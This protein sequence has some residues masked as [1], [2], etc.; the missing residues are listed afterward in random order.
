MG[1][2]NR[3]G[4]LAAALSMGVAGC[5]TF[6]DDGS[7]LTEDDRDVSVA[8]IWNEVLLEGIRNDYARPTVHARNL[9]HSSAAMYDAWAAYDDTASTW[10]LGKTQAGFRCE[11][12]PPNLPRDRQRARE[13]AISFAAYRIIRH[14]FRNSPG[15]DFV[16]E[17]ADGTMA[18]LGYDVEDTG[19]E[20]GSPAA[21]GNRIADCYIGYG[22]QDGSNEANEYAP[23]VYAPVNPP[24]EPED[25]GN[26]DILDMNRWQQI[27]L[28]L[29][30]DQSGN[31]VEGVPAFVGPEW[32]N[33]H[34]FSL[35]AADRAVCRRS[36]FEYP[37]YH[38]PGPPPMTTNLPD[39]YKWT[40]S[41]VSVWSS[42]LDPETGRGAEIVDISPARLG[43]IQKYPV[44]FE[45]HRN[46][47]NLLLGGTRST[48][49]KVNPATGAPYEPQLVPLGDY[50]RAIAEFWADGP[51]SETPPGHWFVIVNTI[52]EHPQFIK[53]FEGRGPI[54]G[55]LEW[56]VKIYF[57]LGGA[58]HDAA[59]AAWS[60]KGCYDYVR[61]V[62]AIRAMADRGQSTDPAD[63]NCPYHVDGIEYIDDPSD[64]AGDGSK[65]VIACVRPGDPLADDP[66][67]PG[68]DALN[69][70]KIKLWAWRGPAYI[71]NS[72]F[73]VA[74]VGW[75][76]AEG[77]WP[78]QRPTFVTPPF[79]GYIS[80]HS[81]YS[82][83]AAEL[84]TLFTGDPY[85]PGGKSEFRVPRNEFL[86]FEDGPSVDITLEWAKY[87][88]ASDQCSL[89]RL[90]G[91]IHPPADDIAGRLI[92]MELGPEAFEHARDYFSG[93]R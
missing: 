1:K 25:P 75:I 29:S 38:D 37:V 19:A 69:V 12:T 89:S 5:D 83:T 70:G 81:T 51:E 31:I 66:Y 13:E 21:L 39:E 87:I 88:D 30:I 48:G 91:G 23:L 74:G 24:I 4:V 56:D 68:V 55:P 67:T 92:G 44:T 34:P 47:Y 53:R 46:F 60:A 85:F 58:M 36:G 45:E 35:T 20:R 41:L 3:I 73:D 65:R 40:H 62:S 17:L 27:S 32:G 43:N 2:K 82:R 64:P 15:A 28:T 80:G 90:W 33:V 57:A 72:N 59:I 22:L 50:T 77:W 84:L 61:P 71:S 7:P 11:Y 16:A 76:L 8:R 6:G 9:W 93:L 52:G 42:H 54:V 78:Y 14:R 10:L 26:P 49:Y 79:A 18:E 86:V 63:P